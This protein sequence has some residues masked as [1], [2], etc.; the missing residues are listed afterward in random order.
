MPPEARKALFG[1][2]RCGLSELNNSQRDVVGVMR[3]SLSGK[4]KPPG[5]NLPKFRDVLSE[6]MKL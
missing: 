4:K 3:S 2:I 6:V 5:T 1:S